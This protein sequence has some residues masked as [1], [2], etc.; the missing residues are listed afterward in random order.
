MPGQ[1]GN[2]KGRPKGTKN[3]STLFEQAI[4]KI[5]KEKKLPIKNPEV[6]LVVKAIVEGLKGNYP[7]FR[8]LMDRKYG[9]PAQPIEHG[10]EIDLKVKAL[11]EL[12]DFIKQLANK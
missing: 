10:G 6:E 3:F 5:V 12:T 4:K 8:D 2:P 9:K 11:E 7:Y 1:S